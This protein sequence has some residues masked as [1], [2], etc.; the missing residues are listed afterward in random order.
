[1]NWKSIALESCDQTQQCQCHLDKF[2]RIILIRNFKLLIRNNQ[3]QYLKNYFRKENFLMIMFLFWFF[4]LINFHNANQRRIWSVVFW[5]FI[6]C[7]FGHFIRHY[8]HFWTWKHLFSFLTLRSWKIHWMGY[9]IHRIWLMR[10]SMIYWRRMM[11]RIWWW[12]MTHWS[13][14]RLIHGIILR[15]TKKFSLKSC[16]K[17]NKLT[18]ADVDVDRLVYYPYSN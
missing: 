18:V 17:Q 9:I 5:W 15:K 3:S 6:R 13:S 1:M 16:N 8:M 12:W 14:K 11:S 2:E 4:R 7:S 10:W